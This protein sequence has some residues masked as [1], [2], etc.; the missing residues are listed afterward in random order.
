MA[1]FGCVTVWQIETAEKKPRKDEK[2]KSKNEVY[3]VVI[4]P[5]NTRDT[6]VRVHGMSRCAKTQHRTHT[7]DTRDLI[8]TGFPVPVPNPTHCKLA[9]RMY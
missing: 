3:L 5:W 9:W 6:V 8:T 7:R 2:K 1:I 4:Y